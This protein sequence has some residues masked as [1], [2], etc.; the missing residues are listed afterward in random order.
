MQGSPRPFRRVL[1]LAGLL[2]ATLAL[3]GQLALGTVIPLDEA[4]RAQL[5][6]LDAASMLC[7]PGGNGQAPLH[8]PGIGHALCPLFLASAIPGAWAAPAPILPAPPPA[9]AL[10]RATPPPARAPPSPVL[11]AAYPRGPPSLA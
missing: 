9:L 2:A 8:H 7:H 1:G 11:I 3:V 6:A 5:A 4:P 10:R